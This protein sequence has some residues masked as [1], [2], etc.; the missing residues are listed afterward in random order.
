MG[1]HHDHV[2]LSPFGEWFG[3]L[4]F[5]VEFVVGRVRFQIL[6]RRASPLWTLQKAEGGRKVSVISK[7]NGGFYIE[8]SSDAVMHWRDINLVMLT[9]HIISPFQSIFMDSLDSL[10]AFMGLV[11]MG[12]LMWCGRGSIRWCSCRSLSQMCSLRQKKGN[13]FI[14]AWGKSCEFL[15]EIHVSMLHKILHFVTCFWCCLWMWP[16]RLGPNRR[17][18]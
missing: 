13:S 5:P 4:G 14:R 17:E 1:K 7:K 6:K 10:Q 3:G 15:K 9:F 16:F 12:R 2:R 18:I 11:Q 8:E